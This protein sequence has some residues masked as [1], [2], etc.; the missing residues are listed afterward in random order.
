MCRSITIYQTS[1]FGAPSATNVFCAEN[2]SA[3]QLYRELPVTT[4]NSGTGAHHDLA[5]RESDLIL[6]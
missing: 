5:K 6:D 1:P 2:W 4:I 3:Y